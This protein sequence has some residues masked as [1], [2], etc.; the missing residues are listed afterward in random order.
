[1]K[2]ISVISMNQIDFF[3]QCKVRTQQRSKPFDT[4]WRLTILSLNVKTCTCNSLKCVVWVVSLLQIIYLTIKLLSWCAIMRL[5]LNQMN[6]TKKIIALESKCMTHLSEC[7]CELQTA[8]KFHLFLISSTNK[9][10]QTGVIKYTCLR[11]NSFHG[12]R[13]LIHCTNI[14]LCLSD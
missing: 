10:N 2:A 11:G 14:Y 7:F 6:N 1:M 5:E 8:L 3:F 13:F 9:I 4:C 12:N